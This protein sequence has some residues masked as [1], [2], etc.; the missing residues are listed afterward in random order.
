[1]RGLTAGTQLACWA[2]DTTTMLVS[3]LI[4]N[5]YLQHETFSFMM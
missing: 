4:P 1:M 5:I 2:S 3:P